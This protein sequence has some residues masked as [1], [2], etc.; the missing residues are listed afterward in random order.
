MEV[1]IIFVKLFIPIEHTS[2]MNISVGIMAHNEEQNIHNLL[3]TLS[4][5]AD[6][7]IVVSSSTDRT[8]EI[9]RKYPNIQLIE[10]KKRIGKA[11]SINQ[12]LK[13]AKNNILVLCSADVLPAKNALLRLI[14]PLNNKKTGIVATRPVPISENTLLNKI[15][16]LQWR[17]H[18][19]LSLKN[20]KFGEMIAFR[21]CFDSI[22]NTAVDEEQIA[23]LVQEQ[24]FSSVY[25]GNAVVTN[26][27]PKSISDF[28]LQR[29]RIYC[30]H[31]ELKKKHDY[32]ASSVGNLNVA[33][34]ALRI[35]NPSNIHIITI[36]AIMEIYG[37]MLGTADYYLN[38]RHYIWK[39]SP[40]TKNDI[41]NTPNV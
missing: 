22:D 7:I 6:E 32:H 38:N 4:Q 23:R 18:H 1:F 9:V 10:Q 13:T 29:R 12:F 36:A 21:R 30:G 34:T 20:P 27:G 26:I 16:R 5:D 25:Q 40:S 3:D 33:K 8:N 28:L 2:D 35:I 39:M 14:E 37:R 31:L 15:V 24:G 41:Y 19:E 11:K 17:F